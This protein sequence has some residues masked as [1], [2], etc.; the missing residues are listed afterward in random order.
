[1]SGIPSST[2]MPSS[3]GGGGTGPV[4]SGPQK[5]DSS[6]GGQVGGDDA[7]ASNKSLE[8]IA[9]Q[10]AAV[11][12]SDAEGSSST[13]EKKKQE[14]QEKQENQK[15]D[16]RKGKQVASQ[17]ITGTS[18]LSSS[19]DPSATQLPLTTRGKASFSDE[20]EKAGSG[21]PSV[22][23]Y[24]MTKAKTGG[25]ESP[26]QY[27]KG[28][29]VSPDG[30]SLVVNLPSQKDIANTLKHFGIETEDISNVQSVTLLIQ[31]V[32]PQA[33]GDIWQTSDETGNPNPAKPELK[34]AQN[35][36]SQRNQA[37]PPPSGSSNASTAN[38]LHGM[39]EG[40]ALAESFLETDHVTRGMQ[41]VNGEIQTKSRELSQ[42]LAQ[43]IREMKDKSADDSE[44]GSIVSASL[45]AT[46][47][48]MKGVSAIGGAAYGYN[49]GM[50]ADGLDSNMMQTVNTTVTTMTDGLWST[51]LT[52]PGQVTDAKYQDKSKKEA[53]QAEQWS[54]VLQTLNQE[55]S[56]IPL[57][58]R[59]SNL[60]AFTEAQRN[61]MGG[62]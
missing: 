20:Q 50:S 32:D 11:A 28:V 39:A 44:Y 26:Q 1:M 45:N 36:N 42:D 5:G 51:T 35:E 30:N 56:Q 62:K 40:A 15:L 46:A 58:E 34:N 48:F 21:S 13:I 2:P 37:P 4:S 60:Q 52:L 3:S 43:D 25:G 8:S 54:N 10:S 38:Y 57:P 23:L 29:Y 33:T 16:Q 31:G 7:S 47:S 6:G 49:K 12:D 19:K 24:V 53:N 59:T 61:I 55:P 27:G 17:E 14:K 9:E 41:V 22:T 18:T